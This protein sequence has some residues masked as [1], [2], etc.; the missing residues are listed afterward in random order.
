MFRLINSETMVP[1][2]THSRWTRTGSK[3]ENLSKGLVFIHSGENKATTRSVHKSH[4][5]MASFIIRQLV[6]QF[7]SVNLV[8]AAFG[9]RIPNISN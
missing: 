9:V 2:T 6:E 1:D 7:W 5:I 8:T 3:K 4:N